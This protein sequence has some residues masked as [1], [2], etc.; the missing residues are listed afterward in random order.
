MEGAYSDHLILLCVAVSSTLWKGLS[1][2]SKK[3]RTRHKF[4]GM[5]FQNV[6][7]RKGNLG[8]SCRR[9][10]ERSVENAMLNLERLPSYSEA[11]RSVRL[12]SLWNQT[13]LSEF[14][15]E[16]CDIIEVDD[17]RNVHCGC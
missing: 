4:G 12:C 6:L 7:F 8:M 2:G 13:S 16:F 3:S 1:K 17:V 5:R 9:S 11:K 10:Y 14:A 15:N